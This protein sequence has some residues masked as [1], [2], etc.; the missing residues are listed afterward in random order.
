MNRIC[1]FSVLVIMLSACNAGGNYIEKEKGIYEITQVEAKKK[2]TENIISY[3]AGS[4]C[5]NYLV[6]KAYGRG[7]IIQVWSWP[8]LNYIGDFLNR[9]REHSEFLT[10]NWCERGAEDRVNL[11][12][13]QNRRLRSYAVDKDTVILKNEYP[14]IGENRNDK[15]MLKPY[16]AAMQI[17]DGIFVLRA[18]ESRYDELSVVNLAGGEELALYEDIMPRSADADQYLEYNYLMSTNSEYIVKAY[19]NYNRLEILKITD[20]YQIVPKVVIWGDE[21]TVDLEHFYYN[22]VVCAE[23]IFLALH[24]PKGSENSIIEIFNYDGELLNCLSA[25]SYFTNIE[26]DSRLNTILCYN[27]DSDENIFY[28]IDLNKVA[29]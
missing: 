28:I 8:E 6:T 5:D 18:S 27:G 4:L 25:N 26:Y 17:R 12:D 16:V 10:V 11:Y 22:D 29:N 19:E 1:I 20:G 9:G 14:L 24:T 21:R 13:I 15:S 23:K 7:K 2:H 3:S